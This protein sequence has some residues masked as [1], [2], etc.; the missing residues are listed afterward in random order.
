MMNVN[1]WLK[2]WVGCFMGIMATTVTAK[3][4]T[5]ASVATEIIEL[6]TSEGCSSC[7]PA[8]KW[9]RKLKGDPELFKKF[10]PLAYHVDYWDQLGWTDRFARQA[11]SQRQYLHQTEGNIS[12]VYTPGF[13]VNNKEWRGWFKGK[14]RWSENQKEVGVLNVD[15]NQ[16]QQLGVSFTPTSK[17]EAKQLLINVAILGMNLSTEVKRGENS[18]RQLLHDFVV[19]SHNQHNVSVSNDVVQQWQVAA[20]EFTES[21]EAQNALVVWLS[22]PDSQKVIQ[23]TG[24]YL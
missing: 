7:P 21:S 12:Q 15:Y 19:L 20:P 14:Y 23:A 11:Y 17:V 5:S 16:N 24:G 1:Y 8:D 2:F 13:V 9:L 3:E 22:H 4:Y 18:G 10:I 6:Y